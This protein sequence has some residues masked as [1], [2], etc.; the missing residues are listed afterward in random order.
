M[1]GD[2]TRTTTSARTA[3][4]PPPGGVMT[5][6]NIGD[7]LNAKHVTWGWFQGGFA[8]TSTNSAARSAAPPTQHVGGDQVDRVL[9]APGSVPVLRHDREPG[10]PGADL[11]GRDRPHR[12]GQPPVRPVRLLRRPEGTGGAKL[13]S[14]SYLKA[15]EYQDGHPGESGPTD[16]QRFLVNT[17]NQIEKSK[18]WP[19]TAIVVTYDDSDGW[20]DHLPP[21]IVNGSNDGI[22][23]GEPPRAGTTPRCAPRARWAS[24]PP[25]AGSGTASGCRWWS[26][27]PARGRTTSASNLTA[28]TSV[29]QFIE[30]NWLRRGAHRRLVRRDLGQPVRQGRA[31]RLQR[32]AAPHPGDP[33]PEER[34]RRPR[35]W[36]LVGPR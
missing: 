12:P 11:A 20:Y 21:K 29:V 28:T 17:I 10:P 32:Q 35:R 34:R 6:K 36:Q 24:A 25:T 26:S 2:S 15:P 16:E 1:Y 13:P 8:P 31:A 27:R 9:A 19:S 7:L 4:T 14:V 23:T 5:G 30:N 33:R 22:N 3:T 18:Y